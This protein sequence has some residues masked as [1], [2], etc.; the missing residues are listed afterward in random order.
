MPPYFLTKWQPLECGRLA[1]LSLL[2]IALLS[3]L[4]FMA[5]LSSNAR[6]LQSPVQIGKAL[7]VEGQNGEGTAAQM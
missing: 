3:C 6:V 5:L 7:S 4:D 2:Q 1:F